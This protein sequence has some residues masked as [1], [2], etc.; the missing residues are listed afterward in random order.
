MAAGKPDRIDMLEHQQ[1][2]ILKALQGISAILSEA[3]QAPRTP[4]LREYNPILTKMKEGKG[5]TAAEYKTLDEFTD[6]K[7]YSGVDSTQSHIMAAF[8]AM[9]KKCVSKP[10]RDQ[11]KA[12]IGN[13]KIQDVMGHLAKISKKSGDEAVAAYFSGP[14]VESLK[15]K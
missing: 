12:A 2:K 4:E 1:E 3:L 7:K 15:S 6:P 11:N 5:I 13:L 8:T 10:V 14:F 9:I